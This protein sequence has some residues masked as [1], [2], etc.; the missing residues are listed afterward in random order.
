MTNGPNVGSPPAGT[1]ATVVWDDTSTKAK[2]G[3]W[4]AH[5]AKSTSY[6]NQMHTYMK[7]GPFDL[8]GAIDAKVNFDYW[9]DTEPFFDFFT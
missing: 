8:T 9:L 3:F 4:S 1:G 6:A 5:P 2:R 7:Y